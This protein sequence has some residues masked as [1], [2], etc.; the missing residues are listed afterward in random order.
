MEEKQRAPI[1]VLMVSKPSTASNYNSINCIFVTVFKKCKQ[2]E[3]KVLGVLKRC[4]EG[5]DGSG[6]KCE[7]DYIPKEEAKAQAEAAKEAA[8]R[9]APKEEAA[10]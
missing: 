8:A 1:N 7:V 6:K 9:K 3:R 10:Q 4:Q 2:T 5:N